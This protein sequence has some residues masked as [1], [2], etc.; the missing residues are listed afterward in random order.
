MTWSFDPFGFT[1]PKLK[2]FCAIIIRGELISLLHRCQ[3][4]PFFFYSHEE[5][6]AC[7]LKWSSLSVYIESVDS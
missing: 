5:V 4:M 7:F 3:I 6:H 2:P 1:S